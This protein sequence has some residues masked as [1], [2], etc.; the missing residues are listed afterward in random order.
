MKCSP[1]FIDFKPFT[2]KNLGILA[3][4]CLKN[5]FRGSWGKDF[6]PPSLVFFFPPPGDSTYFCVYCWNN[7]GL[8]EIVSRLL[9][10]QEKSCLMHLCEI[11]QSIRP[12][13]FWTLY[14][15]WHL[16]W[17]R[18]SHWCGLLTEFL[19][20]LI[21]ETHVALDGLLNDIIWGRTHLLNNRSS[22]RDRM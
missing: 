3:G 15:F 12:S 19:F 17:M 18:V 13:E 5:G 20:L 10:K 6:T 9:R 1:N 8:I 16:R 22:E 14:L 7:W 2:L 21:G 11:K 4:S